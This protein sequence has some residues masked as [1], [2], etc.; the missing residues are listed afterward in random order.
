MHR[1]LCAIFF[2]L[3]VFLLF[4]AKHGKQL[5]IERYVYTVNGVEFAM[6]RVDAGVFT[7]GGTLEQRSDILSTDK[8]LHTVLL[9]SYY[10]AETEVTHRLWKAVMGDI[11]TA[12]NDWIADDLP[13]EWVSWFDCQ[14]FIRRL[15]SITGV[16][17]RL[18]TEA[19]WEYAARGG[20][21]SRNYRFAGG[22]NVD[23]V[24]WVYR[25]SGSRTHAVAGKLP[26]ELGLY[27]MTGNVWEWCADMFSLY[28]DS[29][30]VNPLI[31]TG[32]MR[33]I[34]GGSWDNALDNV[35]L[36]VRQSRDPQ[37]TFYDCGLRLAL[38]AERK[39]VLEVLP[40][41][42]RVFVR[43]HNLRFLLVTGD[44]IAPYYI[45]ETEVTQSLWRSMMHKNPSH[46]KRLKNPVEEVSWT[47]CR[48]FISKLNK[49]LGLNFRL[50]T[51]EEWLYAAQGG[52]HSILYERLDGKFDSLIVA[53]NRPEYATQQKR[54]SRTR[55]NKYLSLIKIPV[56]F[57]NL[58]LTPELPEY[59][60]AILYDYKMAKQ[61]TA[62]YVYAGS[63]IANDVAWHYGNSKSRPHLVRFKKPNELGLYDMSGNVAEWT[64]QQTVNGGSWFDYEN[65][66]R[67]VDYK[68]MHPSTHTPYVGLRLVLEPTPKK[69]K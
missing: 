49:R 12:N 22:N 67:S 40:K 21:Y 25:N 36:S 10:I 69:S 23:E 26:N 30:Q 63:D 28:S 14:E 16:N 8:P 60:D 44:S 58:V 52:Q 24:G 33:V 19:E 46:R 55:A 27:D 68:K 18:P 61:D 31:T 65:K 34:R 54:K 39:P 3:S 29:L 2:S 37:Y 43:G 15:D 32:E 42:K 59:E 20:E 17:F 7:M 51:A 9:D 11:A 57:T 66:C 38:T 4:A 64:E 35:H 56:P 6:K 41:E 1:L 62:A 13:Q 48:V 5:Q 50:P 47:D 45:A 53:L